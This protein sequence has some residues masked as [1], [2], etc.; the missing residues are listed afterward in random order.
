MP[1]L[2]TGPVEL[3]ESETQGHSPQFIGTTLRLRFQIS[4]DKSDPSNNVFPEVSIEVSRV[5]SWHA[6]QQ[7]EVWFNSHLIGTINLQNSATQV[8][9][10]PVQPK[11]INVDASANLWDVPQDKINELTINLGSGGFGLNDSFDINFIE[12]S[13]VDL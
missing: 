7:H 9:S 13:N 6:W 11:I 10:F 2:F 4:K 1:R 5:G 3:S 8:L 12:I